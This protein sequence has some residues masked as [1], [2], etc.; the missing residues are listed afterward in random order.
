MIMLSIL[1]SCKKEK[2]NETNEIENVPAPLP[3]RAR[4][5]A[6]DQDGTGSAWAA[7]YDEK[8][9]N[10][11]FNGDVYLNGE[12]LLTSSDYQL[13]LFGMPDLTVATWSVDALPG[14]YYPDTVLTPVP[15]GSNGFTADTMK[16]FDK[17]QNFS[18]DL[19]NVTWD[20][21]WVTLGGVT[22][23]VAGHKSSLSVI[24][25]P[26]DSAKPVV[27]P[28]T[29]ITGVIT[30]VNTIIIPIKDGRWSFKTEGQSSFWYPVK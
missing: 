29:R 24:F 21:L 20:T 10:R 4:F 18:I 15:F 23:K 25:T 11:Y 17:D 22:K 27:A 1:I 5:Q 28:F 8:S 26:Q 6:V 3:I 30:G 13:R 9:I 19:M 7:F 16:H 2:K 12:K 14:Y